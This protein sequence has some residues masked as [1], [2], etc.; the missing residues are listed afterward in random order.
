MVHVHGTLA[1]MSLITNKVTQAEAVR[2]KMSDEDT[3]L[4]ASHFDVM[5]KETWVVA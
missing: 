2:R 1:I 3:R 5:L 4:V